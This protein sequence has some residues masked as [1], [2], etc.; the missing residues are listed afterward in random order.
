MLEFILKRMEHSIARLLGIG[1]YTMALAWLDMS[2]SYMLGG[3]LVA[4]A[5]IFALILIL[6]EAATMVRGRG[7]E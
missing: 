1:L 4:I 7:H 6:R 2:P 5:G 3:T